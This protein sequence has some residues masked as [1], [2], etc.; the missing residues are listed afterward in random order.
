MAVHHSAL[1]QEGLP[2]EQS[3]LTGP[4]SALWPPDPVAVKTTLSPEAPGQWQS[5]VVGCSAGWCRSTRVGPKR[6][7]RGS[8][9][10]FYPVLLCI[11]LFAAVRP[12][13]CSEGPPCPLLPLPFV[14]SWTFFPV[15]F[16]YIQA[17]LCICPRGFTLTIS[18]LNSFVLLLYRRTTLLLYYFFVCLDLKN[19]KKKKK[20]FFLTYSCWTFDLINSPLKQKHIGKF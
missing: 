7:S 16:L 17:H 11:S 8:V 5:T 6:R 4:V 14:P 2:G 10:L 3:G 20:Y 9:S 19:Q 13:A 1:L 12:A 18:N 15:N